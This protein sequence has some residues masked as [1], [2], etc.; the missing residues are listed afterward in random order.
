MY[1]TAQNWWRWGNGKYVAKRRR[2]CAMKQLLSWIAGFVTLAV[3]AATPEQAQS[4]PQTIPVPTDATVRVTLQK[5]L[6]SRKNKIGDQ[7]I[8]KNVDSLKSGG[9]DVV[10]KGSKVLGHITTVKSHT[11]AEPGSALG[12]VF[13][14]AIL[15]DGREVSLRFTIQAVAPGQEAGIPTTSMTPATAAGSGGVFGPVTGPLTAGSASDPNAGTPGRVTSPESPRGELTP[16]C[17]GVLRME[18]LALAPEEPSLGSVIVSRNRNIQLDIGTQMM[19]R[20]P[21]D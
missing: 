21:H 5:P 16:T 13:D 17:R 4:F 12:I 7:V 11:K 6:D 8:A 2:R 10:P 1:H 3:L 14:H 19:L 9:Q 18:G 20:V 15:K